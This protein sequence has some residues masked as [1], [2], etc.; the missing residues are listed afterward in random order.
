MS[1]HL[2]QL[3][4]ARLLYDLE[5]ARIDEFRN[6]LDRI[7][8][9]AESIEGFVWRLKGDSGNATEIPVAP[10]PMLVANM[11]VWKNVASLKVFAYETD[12]VEFLRKKKL[13]FEKPKGQY[14]VLWWIEEGHNPSLEEGMARLE[15]LE[16]N[17]SSEK[18][19]SFRKIFD[20]K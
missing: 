8:A 12:H 19:F 17:G 7:N 20:P 11:S 18:A 2:A 16:K 1:Y 14:M 3:N 13:W 10:D 4:V 5:D 15:F 9:L 6:N